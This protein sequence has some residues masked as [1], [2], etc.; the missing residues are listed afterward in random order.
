[1]PNL[2]QG[3]FVYVLLP[4]VAVIVGGVVAAFRPPGPRVQSYVQHFAAG[5]VFAATAGEVLPAIT[6]QR[7]P[8]EVVI[9]FAL[10]VAAML[11]IRRLAERSER[12]ETTG[13]AQPIGLIEAWS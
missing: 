11:G 2:I 10:G 12:P 1:M 9:G 8:L 3:V 6:H 4:I 5:V 7:A 13:T